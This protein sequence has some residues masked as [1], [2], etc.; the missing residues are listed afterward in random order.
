M[1]P[2]SRG[3][4]GSGEAAES[5]NYDAID[6]IKT[7]AI[8]AVIFTH[9][10]LGSWRGLHTVYDDILGRGWVSFHVPS[11]LAVSGFLY[12][13]VVPVPG[14]KIFERLARILAPYL[15]AS[16]VA[17]ALGDVPVKDPSFWV[18]LVT[19]NTQG[20][21]YYVVL[22]ASYVPLV[23]VLSRLPSRAAYMILGFFVLYPLLAYEFQPFRFSETHVARMRN[24][25]YTAVYFMGGWVLRL[26]VP[27][28][29]RLRIRMGDGLFWA[30]WITIAV[31]CV[32]LAFAGPLGG[33][34]WQ[35]KLANRM[36]YTSGA[37]ILFCGA[38]QFLA[39]LSAPTSILW[40]GIRFVSG[41]TYTIYL[42]HFFFIYPMRDWTLHWPPVG[43]IF[44]VAT[45]AFIGACLISWLGRRVLGNRAQWWIG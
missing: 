38:T 37:V 29:R 14:R 34:R 45:T 10:V 3:T 28:L 5:R 24:P 42:Y 36:I 17:L 18:R 26:V 32:T 13:S 41:A 33:D 35:I 19:G 22:I 43:R 39:R 44:S 25:V 20:Q 7:G 40:R 4:L 1:I 6:V 11:F 2:E 16:C 21:Y 15:V 8:I 31:G 12:C 23:W 27:D 9:S 30:A